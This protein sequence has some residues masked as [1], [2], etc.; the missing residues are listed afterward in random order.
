M[1]KGAKSVTKFRLAIGKKKQKK[2]NKSTNAEVGPCT[3]LGWSGV[4]P[5]ARSE[6]T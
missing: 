1:R 6:Y 5:H 2:Q 3:A 4:P